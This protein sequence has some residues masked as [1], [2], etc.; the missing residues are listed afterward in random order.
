MAILIGKRV[1]PSKKVSA[2]I[3]AEKKVKPIIVAQKIAPIIE[4]KS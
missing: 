4:A 2:I 1:Y 3:D